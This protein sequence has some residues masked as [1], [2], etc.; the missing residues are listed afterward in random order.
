MKES[1]K[2]SASGHSNE[3]NNN[4]S[5]QVARSMVFLKHVSWADVR[6][7]FSCRRSYIHCLF[8]SMIKARRHFIP[9]FVDFFSSHRNRPSF[10]SWILHFC[11]CRVSWG[12]IISGLHCFPFPQTARWGRETE[13]PL[14]FHLP[15]LWGLR[16]AFPSQPSLQP[17]CYSRLAYPQVE[18]LL[19]G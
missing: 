17:T 6:G 3:Q 18:T 4:S 2:S 1:V 14:H 7:Q 9:T 19:P 11:T 5:H 16:W 13:H 8:L 10:S 12:T 15:V